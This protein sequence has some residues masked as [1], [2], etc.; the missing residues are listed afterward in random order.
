MTIEIEDVV[1]AAPART[2][3][4]T[5]TFTTRGWRGGDPANGPAPSCDQPALEV[6]GRYLIGMVEYRAGDWAPMSGPFVVEVADAGALRGVVSDGP[7]SPFDGATPE[8]V[9]AALGEVEPDPAVVAFR[10][11][12]GG[13][14]YQAAL[15]AV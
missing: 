8:Q 6:G 13:E 12:P 11:L 10:D 3:P 2:V 1:W 14:R 9:G 7:L 15:D 4:T 5:A